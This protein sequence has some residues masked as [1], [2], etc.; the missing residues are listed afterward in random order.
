MELNDHDT[1]LVKYAAYVY[2]VGAYIDTES[3]NQHTFYLLAN[4]TIDG[5]LHKDR[6]ILA[7]LASFKNKSFYNRNAEVFQSWFKEEELAHYRLLGA[8]IKLANSLHTTKRNIVA[9]IELQEDGDDLLLTVI[10]NKDWRAEWYQVEKQKK[11]LEKQLRRNVEL[12]F[13][14]DSH[15]HIS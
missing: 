10:C 3:G 15:S 2:N 4:R 1:F 7:L 13:R 11:H 5:L 9:D 6:I 14:E 8:I 12:V